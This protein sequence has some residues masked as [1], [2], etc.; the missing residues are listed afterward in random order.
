M[1]SFV[2]VLVRSVFTS[3]V[4]QAFGRHLTLL[5]EA[6]AGASRVERH[7]TI[8]NLSEGLRRAMIRAHELCCFPNAGD[9]ARS[10]KIRGQGLGQLSV[11]G[12]APCFSQARAACRGGRDN[13]TAMTRGLTPCKGPGR[14]P[15]QGSGPEPEPLRDPGAERHR[16]LDTTGPGVPAPGPGKRRAEAGV[17][18]NV[19]R[20]RH[21]AGW[22]H[23]VRVSVGRVVI[24]SGRLASHDAAVLLLECL[25]GQCAASGGA[26]ACLRS[27]AE[28]FSAPWP[29]ARAGASFQVVLDVRSILGCR[30]YGP[31]R[32][33]DEAI[34]LRRE[35]LDAESRGP[36]VLLE[37][38][39]HWCTDPEHAYGRRSATGGL[40]ARVDRA[41]RRLRAG[42]EGRG[43]PARA[44]RASKTRRPCEGTSSP[45]RGRAGARLRALALRAE[46]ALSRLAHARGAGAQHAM[47]ASRARAHTHTH[48]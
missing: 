23:R 5:R 27:M 20:V 17:R 26:E 40:A 24:S 39:R 46:A 43:G 41:L 7:A 29:G 37:Q 33:V 19:W 45:G 8:C 18:G 12:P 42:A 13:V 31:A 10:S 21:K 44:P 32:S 2:F 14:A 6:L 36:V 34:A 48:P 25:R 22:Q 30:V 28:T 38:L 16:I 3:L 4:L 11:S 9:C 1:F 15:K 35:V 47:R